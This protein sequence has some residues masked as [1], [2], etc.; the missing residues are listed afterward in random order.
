MGGIGMK[1]KDTGGRR[2]GSWIKSPH[3]AF[4]KGLPRPSAQRW[5]WGGDWD[6]GHPAPEAPGS[7]T[8]A[9][10]SPV[11]P[12]PGQARWP[13][14][15]LI[16]ERLQRGFGKRSALPLDPRPLR[17]SSEAAA[18]MRKKGLLPNMPQP[19]WVNLDPQL[20]HLCGS[21]FVL[22]HMTAQASCK[23]LCL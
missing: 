7:C 10:A 12:P 22:G 2:G 18:S 21:G 15:R 13:T 20:E 11:L 1:E 5:V 16:G 3:F 14:V 9:K 8:A 6:F 17:W 19:P 23:S 4:A